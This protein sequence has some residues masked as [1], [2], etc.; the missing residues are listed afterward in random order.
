MAI[1]LIVIEVGRIEE[2]MEWRRENVCCY[3]C[4]GVI[5]FDLRGRIV[6]SSV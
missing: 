6:F 5:S 4:P 2:K 3:D 1:L